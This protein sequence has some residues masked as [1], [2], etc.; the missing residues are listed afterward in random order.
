ML[1]LWYQWFHE[2]LQDFIPLIT[3]H[4]S[5]LAP[6]VSYESSQLVV[7]LNALQQKQQRIP[8]PTTKHKIEHVQ[9]NFA[10]ALQRDQQ[11]HELRLFQDGKFTDRQRYLKSLT[12]S[13]SVPAEIFLNHQSATT[14]VAKAGLFNDYFQSVFTQMPYRVKTDNKNVVIQL[15]HVYFTTGVHCCNFM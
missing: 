2:I 13:S 11:E 14:D 5:E 7:K 8:T 9:T 4:R 6:W 15:S 3:K 12:K 1:D 10:L